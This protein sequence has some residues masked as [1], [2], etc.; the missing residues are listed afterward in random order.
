M[1]KPTGLANSI[2]NTCNSP[3]N[4]FGITVVIGNPLYQTCTTHGSRA[5]C[6]RRGFWPAKPKILFLS[7]IFFIKTSFNM[8]KNVS[9]GP[10]TY[11][12]NFCSVK[13][14]ELCIPASDLVKKYLAIKFKVYNVISGKN[15]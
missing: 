9:I 15:H 1:M 3:L 8:K 2:A 6:D 13:R 12:K 14:I 4:S 10:R 11:K 5:E 7:L